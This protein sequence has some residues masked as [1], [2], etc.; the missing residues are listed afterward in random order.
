MSASNQAPFARLVEYFKGAFQSADQIRFVIES[1]LLAS[2]SELSHSIPAQILAAFHNSAQPL[3]DTG[4]RD[5]VK[6][7]D[8]SRPCNRF[9]LDSS[10]FSQLVRI[11]FELQPS[12]LQLKLIYCLLVPPKATYLDAFKIWRSSVSEKLILTILGLL[13]RALRETL[14]IGVRSRLPTGVLMIC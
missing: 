5:F 14:L 3:D 13:Q 8:I 11:I 9:R 4:L 10:V 12:L 6:L 7:F 1:I 2:S